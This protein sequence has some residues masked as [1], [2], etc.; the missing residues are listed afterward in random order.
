M[1]RP[2]LLRCIGK[3]ATKLTKWDK[4]TDK[5]LFRMMS[6]INGSLDTRQVG[7]IGDSAADLELWLF[8]DA[9]FA[10]D[11]EDL[12]STSGGFL[13]LAGPNSFSRWDTSARSRRP[14]PTARPRLKSLL[15]TLGCARKE[16]LHL[17]SG[18]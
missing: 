2:E 15:S 18:R 17:I 9:D 12:K 11:R 3:L 5:M 16:F 1:A 4:L 8:V 14:S 13:V 6:Y 7:F 10:G